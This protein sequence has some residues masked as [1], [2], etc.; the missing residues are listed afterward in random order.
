MQKAWPCSIGKCADNCTY[1]LF[2]LISLGML[3]VDLRRIR[4]DK[5][6]QPSLL[7]QESSFAETDLNDTNEDD[8]RNVGPIDYGLAPED[9]YSHVSND[10]NEE[11]LNYFGNDTNLQEGDFE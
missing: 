3:Q 7:Q 5:N 8:T 10:T 2:L 1:K 9:L 6:A 4:G 11:N